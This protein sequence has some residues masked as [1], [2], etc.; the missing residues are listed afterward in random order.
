M[1]KKKLPILYSNLLYKMGGTYSK[2]TRLKWTK[3]LGL[4]SNYLNVFSLAPVGEW[5]HDLPLLLSARWRAHA[6]VNNQRLLID[7]EMLSVTVLCAGDRQGFY[8]NLLFAT[9]EKNTLVS[10]SFF[11]FCTCQNIFF[12][13]F[14]LKW[15]E[16][17]FSISLTNLD[18]L[19]SGLL[20]LKSFDGEGPG[21]HLGR[22]GGFEAALLR[23]HGRR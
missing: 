9:N 15:L 23:L 19:R 18:Q 10:S 22:E 21:P 11:M 17:K 1:F 7:N 3:P 5:G 13:W 20:P 8:M 16:W 14:L 4:L 12:T 6:S 2:G